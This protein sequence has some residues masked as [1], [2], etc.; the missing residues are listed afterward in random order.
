MALIVLIA[1][2]K[3]RIGN[4]EIIENLKK[5]NLYANLVIQKEAMP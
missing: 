5:L 2:N 3:Q 4:I 1:E